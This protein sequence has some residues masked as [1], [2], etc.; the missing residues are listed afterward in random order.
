MKRLSIISIL[1]F[2]F[3]DQSYA[4][5]KITWQQA[6]Q[7]LHDNSIT[8]KQSELREQI[9][10]NNVIIARGSIYPNLAFSANNQHTMGM[11]FDQ[12]SGKLI[13]GN[14]W[15]SY[16]T[17]SLGTSVVVYQ[18][19]QK[20]NTLKA[21]KLNLELAALDTRRLTRE[22]ELQLLGLF[23]QTLINHDLWGAGKSQLQL[24]E[25]LLHQ[26]EVLV[27]VGKRTLIDLSQAKAKLANDKLN[28]IS[29][30][31]AYELSLM[32]LKQLLEMEESEQI[33]PVPP[34][35]FLIEQIQP[36]YRLE[37]DPY[38][39]LLDK[40]IE[41]GELKIKMARS[42]Y[43]PTISLNGNYGTNY[44]SQRENLLSGITIPFWDQFNQNRTLSGNIVV[45]MPIFDGFRTK[46]N[47]KTAKINQQSL[48]Y[49]KEKVTRERKQVISQGSLEYTASQEELNAIEVAYEANKANY[50]AIKE[51]YNVGKS[52]S[53]DVYRALTEFN[54]SEFR[55]ITS[56]YQ[57]FYK[58][59]MLVLLD[60]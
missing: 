18:G 37:F 28:V 43:F 47:T 17:G 13:T 57:V 60:Q 19:G 14:Q 6:V 42:T 54:I 15:S 36:N 26:E 3:V 44:S 35:G 38:I 49:E 31:N 32:K 51:R 48:R 50:E 34:Q 30:K 39:R 58:K 22:L 59:E 24:S 53:I 55:S 9:S 46:M 16:A 10:Q 27:E 25:Q 11:V 23:T 8:L 40:Q 56:R 21:E 41:L 29:T 2:V 1:V 4:Q 12:V 20:Q 5:K 33:E 7:I 45:S 52:S